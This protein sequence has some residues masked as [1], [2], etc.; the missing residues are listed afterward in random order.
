M[1]ARQWDIVTFI[2][3]CSIVSWVGLQSVLRES[4]MFEPRSVSKSF[5]TISTPSLKSTS[6]GLSTKVDNG[7]LAADGGT[8]HA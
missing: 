2:T 8:S 5:Q 1:S 3:K 7:Q 6:F 4:R